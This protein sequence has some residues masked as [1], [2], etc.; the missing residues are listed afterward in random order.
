MGCFK[1]I[2]HQQLS[3]L[4]F[5]TNAFIFSGL[6]KDH[7]VTL[8]F[9]SYYAAICDPSCVSGQGRCSA[10][11]SCSCYPGYVGSRCQQSCP[12][13]SYGQNCASRC[14]CQ[15]S[16]VCNAVTGSCAC[17]AGWSGDTCDQPCS[18]GRYGAGCRFQCQCR[19]D[20]S[21]CSRHTGSCS[22]HP[23]WTGTLCDNTCP[24]GHYGAGMYRELFGQAILFRLNKFL[25]SLNP[26]SE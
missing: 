9:L 14:R 1:A 11:N 15:N 12:T 5:I 21:S 17:T 18:E 24:A 7:F 4:C 25:C 19:E 8:V 10:P 20:T 6:I 2:G 22:C 23:G 3:H 13:G 16:G 26:T